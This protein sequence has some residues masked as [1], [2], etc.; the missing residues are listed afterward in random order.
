MSM[1]A[2]EQPFHGNGVH[3]PR[4]ADGSGSVRALGPCRTP[5]GRAVDLSTTA[6]RLAHR[7]GPYLFSAR[8]A[9]RVVESDPRAV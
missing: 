3:Q 8:L 1:A 9:G 7:R 4:R 2:A 6:S 5:A